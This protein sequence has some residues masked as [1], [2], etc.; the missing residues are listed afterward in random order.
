MNEVLND[1]VSQPSPIAA[2]RADFE[3][4][5]I[6]ALDNLLSGRAYMGK[7]N[8]NETSEILF[9]L[10]HAEPTEARQALDRAMAGWFEK[11][12]ESSPPAFPAARWAEILQNAFLTVD[13]LDLREAYD[14]LLSVHA[15]GRAW[16]RG[17]YLNPSRDPEAA[18]LR[19]LALRQKHQGLLPVWMRL[20]RME[21]N[22]PLHYASL[23]LLGLRKL[24][25]K[26]GEP[27]GDLQLVFFS[28]LVN[29]AKAIAAQIKDQKAARDFWTME[30]RAILALYPRSTHY[31]VEK[32]LPLVEQEA[33]GIAG[34]WLGRI[35][36]RLKQELDA[37]R[38]ITRIKRVHLRPPSMDELKRILQLLQKRPLKEVRAELT[39][40]LAEHRSYTNQ[41]GYADFLVKTFCNIGYKILK[42]DPAWAQRLVEE[43]FLWAPY[44]PFVWTE[45]AIIE[46]HQ[47]RYERAAGLLWEAKRKFPEDEKIR[48]ILAEILEREGKHEVAEIVYRQAVKDFPENP[49]C[50]TGLAEVLAK[51]DRLPEAEV[52][53]RQ[54]MKEFQDEPVCRAGLA[55]VLAKLDRLPEAEAIYRQAV[56]DFPD[57]AVCR[58]GL[59]EVLAKQDRLPE[60]EAIYRQA[61][62]DFPKNAFGRTGLAEV[63]AKQNRLPEAEVIYRQ[64][65]KEFQDEPV[66]RAGLAEVLAKLDRLPEAEAIYRQAV[67]DFQNNPVCR[68]GLAVVLLKQRD[69]HAEGMRLLEET[70]KKFPTNL[71][72]KGLLQKVKGEE[73]LDTIEVGFENISEAALSTQAG[74]IEMAFEAT[75]EEALEISGPLNEQSVSKVADSSKATVISEADERKKK[76]APAK[77]DR[78]EAAPAMASMLKISD[79]E[80]LKRATEI[81]LANL[82]RLASRW[83]EGE[84]QESYRKEALAACDQA[85]AKAPDNAWALLAKGW[86]LLDQEPEKAY[87]F[88]TEHG[89]RSQNVLGF[90]IGRLRAESFKGEKALAAQWNDLLQ[91]HP[92]RRTILRLEHARQ[93]LFSHNGTT[94]PALE[95]LRKQLT[96]NV[97]ELPPIMWKNEEW[98]LSTVKESLFRGVDLENPLTEKAIPQVLANHAESETLLRGVVEQCLTSDY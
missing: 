1:K 94:L 42:K 61:V 18:F 59:A 38:P 86:W 84:Q 41:T 64:A 44:N 93:E 26:N 39:T 88:F 69:K 10:F 56:K 19:T 48:S 33:H 30:C 73:N 50:R 83:A 8:R 6:D 32:F 13:R 7:L 89:E 85:L 96:R 25:E 17:L 31:W 57:D 53:Y 71:I 5:P 22:L 82:Y 65:M 45:R 60:A 74:A 29:L 75:P 20:C 54:A 67:K 40:F 37:P 12:W 77:E 46:A 35:I 58:N 15:S 81:G 90:Q 16:L 80:Q 95:E 79:D 11:Y 23:G 4:R 63:L 87:N 21:E 72:A 36:P 28:G 24:P 47:G 62:K 9:R 78:L 68:V 66:C 70:A 14:W 76:E 92:R 3:K 52:I 49:V 2:W 43:A 91:H 97:Q 27:A 98:V 51:Q 55:E 34:E